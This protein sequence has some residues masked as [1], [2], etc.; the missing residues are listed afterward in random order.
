VTAIDVNCGCP[1]HFS[2]SGGMGAALLS[3]PEQLQAILMTLVSHLSI[4]VTCKIRLLPDI[5]K[6]LDLCR[7]IEATG[8][9][10]LAVH[11]RTPDERPRHRAHWDRL[12]AIVNALRIPVIANGDIEVYN[13]IEKIKSLTGAHSIMIAR[14]AQANPSVF[15][16]EGFLSQDRILKDYLKKV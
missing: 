5:E 4:P 1:K 16:T 13:D 2:I 15:R 12:P 3:R 7:T 8:V 10:A 9:A 14:A 6:T 11:L